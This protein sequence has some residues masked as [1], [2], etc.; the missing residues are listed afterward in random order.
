MLLSRPVA[1]SKSMDDFDILSTREM[2][3]QAEVD[4]RT[5]QRWIKQG[6]L[7]VE[8][9]PHGKYRVNPLDLIELSLP[10]TERAAATPTKRRLSYDELYDRL[11]QVTFEVEELEHRL[12]Q[13]EQKI[14]RLERQRTQARSSTPMKRKKRS[15]RSRSTLPRDLVTWRSFA[16]LHSIPESTVA[17][18]I[19]D[20]RIW[21]ERGFWTV[22][23]RTVQEALDY[24]GIKQFIDLFEEHPRFTECDECPHGVHSW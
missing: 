18:A 23:G 13:A 11:I 3:Q 5:V 2:A 21:V 16:R 6:K 17:R 20:E 14:E 19:R 4:V 22:D 1:R 15:S 24:V 12:T 7:Q 10:L 8:V 9:L